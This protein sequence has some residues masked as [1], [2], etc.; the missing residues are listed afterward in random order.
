LP[1]FEE[2]DA[3]RLR[4]LVRF[5]SARDQE[6]RFELLRAAAFARVRLAHAM[7]SRLD[8]S[9]RAQARRLA[10]LARRAGDGYERLSRLGGAIRF[11]RRLANLAGR[12]A[13][14]L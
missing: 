8:A 2:L 3:D 7:S 10:E 5:E 6:L 12:K 1:D 11:S 13:G 4:A 14:V 9:R